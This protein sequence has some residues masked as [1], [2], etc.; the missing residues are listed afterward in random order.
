M[1]IEHAVDLEIIIIITQKS[2]LNQN[3]VLC[4]VYVKIQNVH[5]IINMY[6]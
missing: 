6:F 2:K 5:L 4:N 3:N 1:R